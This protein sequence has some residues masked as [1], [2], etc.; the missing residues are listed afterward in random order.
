VRPSSKTTGGRES[1]G[2]L[3]VVTHTEL[4]EQVADAVGSTYEEAHGF[5]QSF[6]DIVINR[7][8]AGDEVKIRGLGTFKW[9]KV[10]GKKI[11]RHK[12]RAFNGA[13]HLPGGK[14]LRFIPAVKL[15]TRRPIMPDEEEGMNKY[16]VVTDDTDD[17]TAAVEKVCPICGETLD[18]GGACPKHG[19]EPFESD[20]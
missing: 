1:A 9:M 20:E 18:S 6:I 7:L 4:I 17:K 13:L 19:T 2:R 16:A 10:K 14:K 8:D 15:R 11:P 5:I 3:E 12:R